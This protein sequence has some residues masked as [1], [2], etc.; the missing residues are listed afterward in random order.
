[1][2]SLK[3]QQ[4]VALFVAMMILPMILLMG[5]VSVTGSFMD[6]KMIDARISHHESRINLNSTA[7]H[8]INTPNVSTSFAVATTG[9]VF[10]SDKFAHSDATA[11]LL[12]ESTCKRRKNA[13]GDNFKC[14]YI[15]LTLSERYGRTNQ[16]GHQW[17]EN[18]LSVGIELP[19]FS[20]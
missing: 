9:S 2:N 17:G 11:E 1:M 8:I 5:I 15:D 6:L 10:R 20:E 19:F 13:F 12:G 7:S 4:G 14:K 16:G 18:M 3:R